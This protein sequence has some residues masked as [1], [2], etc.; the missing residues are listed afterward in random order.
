MD[1]F[2]TLRRNGWLADPGERVRV[3]AIHAP[4]CLATWG[5][6]CS[7]DPKLVLA[8]DPL[9]CRPRDDDKNLPMLDLAS[10]E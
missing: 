6:S 9:P 10:G 4:G 7:C 8:V 2:E 5:R 1:Y 3:V